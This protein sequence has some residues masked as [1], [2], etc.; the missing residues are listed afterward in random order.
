MFCCTLFATGL[1]TH[2]PE[3]ETNAPSGTCANHRVIAH[4][5]AGVKRWCDFCGKDDA[6]VKVGNAAGGWGTPGGGF[7]GGLRGR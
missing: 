2:D 7:S 5:T 3:C 1:G 6:G 4:D